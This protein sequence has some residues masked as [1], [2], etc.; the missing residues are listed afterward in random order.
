MANV[1]IRVDDALK[2]EAERIFSALGLS[3]SAATTVFYKQ[4]V[5]CG[6]IPFETRVSEPS[7]TRAQ[8]K[9]ALASFLAFAK[10]NQL[11]E[12]GYKF[13]RDTCYEE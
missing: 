12:P 7:L 9:A 2:Q 5:S 3:M 4:V 6:G 10:E 13:R 8:R 1:N 11:I